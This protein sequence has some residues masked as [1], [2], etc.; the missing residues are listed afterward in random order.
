MNRCR[1]LVVAVCRGLAARGF[2]CW[3]PDLPGTGESLRVLDDVAWADWTAAIADAAALIGR[4]TGTSPASIAI[5]GGALLDAPFAKR[6]RLSPVAGASLHADLRR[7]GLTGEAFAGYAMSPTLAAS[8]AAA[9]PAGDARTV[10]LAGDERDA[11]LRLDGPPP[12][13]RAE[14]VSDAA[15]SA[16]LI[17]DIAAFCRHPGAGRAPCPEA[18]DPGLRRN[19]GRR[20]IH[21]PYAGAHLAATIDGPP[22]ATAGWVFVT[23]G[24][25]TRVGPHRLYERLAAA[26]AEQNEAVIRFDRPGTGDSPGDDPGFDDNAAAISA[27]VHALRDACPG[28]SR[29]TGFGL[30]DGS[31]ALALHGRA[32]GIDALVLA[33]PWVV[34]P[35]ADLP[36]A[37]AIRGHYR[38]RLKDPRA[39]GR[40][41][42]GGVDLRKLARGIVR[43]ATA[44]A[45]PLAVRLA[46][47]LPA[48]TRIVLAEGDNTARAFEAAWCTVADAPAIE[49]VRIAT[50]SHSFAGGAAFAGLAAALTRRR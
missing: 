35:Q 19:D 39:W 16:S 21:L 11:D 13:R 3:L 47:G 20:V 7:A 12:W 48:G 6:W 36:P 8:L 41:L 28:L 42:R 1:A 27:A 32:A 30:C 49:R 18:L 31:T 45:A 34:A 14:P 10:R 17:D 4:E 29:I 33:N 43:S 26:I 9:V 23:G 2:G 24:T 50:S 46:Q 40:L 25:Q 37:A 44:E 22:D 5:R 15:L 38:D